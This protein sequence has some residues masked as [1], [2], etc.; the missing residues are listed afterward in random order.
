MATPQSVIHG[1][2]R[3]PAAL[4]PAAFLALA[5]LHVWELPRLAASNGGF[6]FLGAWLLALLLLGLPLVLLELMLGKRARRA[7][8]EGLAFLTREADAKRGWRFAAWGGAVAVFL[9][10]AAMALVAGG[11]VNFL[12]RDLGIAGAAVTM[13][14][15]DGPALPLGTGTLL[16]LAA[17]FSL[18]NPLLR[19]RLQLGG[20]V[21]ASALL[22]V[23]AIA[24]VGM[25]EVTYPSRALTATDWREAVRL[26]LLSLGSGLGVVWLA[27]MRLPKDA[28]L[29]RLALGV[30]V[31]QSVFA[32]LLLLAL[33]PFVAA[34]QANAAGA[35]PDI[36][37]TGPG[38]WVVLGSLLLT[39][40]LALP[41]V[42]EPVLLRLAE[43]GMGRLPAVVLVFVGVGLLAEAVWLF[44]HATGVLALLMVLYLLLM[45]VLLCLSLFAGWGMK[46]SH[47]RKELALP[48][49]GIY[50]LWRV[51]VRLGVPLAIAW[52]LL[53]PFV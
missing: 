4:M 23:A 7:P 43:R 31:L 21:L 15:A 19:S 20:L 40:V 53:Q 1:T 13:A 39:T 38:V 36:V 35:G 37:P 16:L 30:L 27:G 44:G 46:I 33:A 18:I 32:V 17:A 42:A 25:A 48:A 22:L 3:V 49:E 6:A 8:L 2:S 14:S 28:P 41:Q 24:G 51:A 5:M 47:A 50:N 11:S 29:G 26:A 12:V 52:V 9:A 45:L 10:M 34:L